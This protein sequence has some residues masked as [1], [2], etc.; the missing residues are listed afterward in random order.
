MD[1]TTCI[2]AIVAM[3]MLPFDIRRWRDLPLA[4]LI[5]MR[6]TPWRNLLILLWIVVVASSCSRNYGNDVPGDFLLIVDAQ[7]AAEAT[8]NINLQI[9]ANGKGQ[10][11]RYDTGGV[12]RGDLENMVT[13]EASQVVETREFNLNRDELKNLW[14]AV[15]DNNIFELTGDYRSPRGF[16]YAFIMIEADGRKH[17]VF[18]I[19]MEVPAIKA[20]VEATDA[21]LPIGVN[22]EY[23]EGYLP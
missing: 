5:V 14:R 21:V 12:I 2:S 1:A 17:Q 11:E 15:E 16:S 9:K 22:L 7:S 19:G 6:Q 13:Y 18:N 8:Q 23:R 4:G 10:Y 20:M 3:S